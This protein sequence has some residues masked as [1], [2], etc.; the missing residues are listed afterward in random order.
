SGRCPPRAPA[1]P[2]RP[3]EGEGTPCRQLK[4]NDRHQ[5]WRAGKHRRI[6]VIGT[7]VFTRTSTGRFPT[8]PTLSSAGIASL[9]PAD[10]GPQD[11]GGSCLSASSHA[12]VPARGVLLSSRARRR[13]KPGSPPDR[14]AAA[15]QVRSPGLR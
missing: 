14:S 7:V 3:A 6:S 5:L 4:E 10:L 13:E 11:D 2:M 1:R 8:P 12:H 15:R 9:L